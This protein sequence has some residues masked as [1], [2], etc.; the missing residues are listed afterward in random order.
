MTNRLTSPRALV[1]AL[2][3]AGVFGAAGMGVYTKAYAVATPPIVVNAA[4]AASTP[5]VTLPDFSTITKRDG[6]AVVNISVTG[7]TRT[8]SADG[9]PGMD[10]D[11]P[12]AEFF[13]RF[14]GQMGRAARSSNPSAKCRHAAKARAS[15]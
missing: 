12:M 1:I 10:P 9:I 6:P 7:S 13:R 3:A 4:T 5:L 15:S 8:A 2:A 14:Q 11:D